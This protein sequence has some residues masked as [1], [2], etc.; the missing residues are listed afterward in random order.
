MAAHAALSIDAGAS[1]G[2][3]L[4][5]A[6]AA[7]QRARADTS[8]GAETL[9]GVGEG[10]GAM[11]HGQSE[12]PIIDNADEVSPNKMGSGSSWNNCEL[13]KRQMTL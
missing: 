1:S 12:P 6:Q 10:V 2:M 11:D 13:R 9:N 3:A 7:A 8:A 5:A 4:K